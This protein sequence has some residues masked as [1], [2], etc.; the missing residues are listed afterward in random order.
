VSQRAKFLVRIGAA[1]GVDLGAGL[2]RCLYWYILMMYI[3]A[4]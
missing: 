2:F 4:R 1:G 3:L